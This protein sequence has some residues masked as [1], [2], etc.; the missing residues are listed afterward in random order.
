MEKVNQPATARLDLHQI[1]HEI[2]TQLMVIRCLE[3]GGLSEAA[4]R[5]RGLLAIQKAL[6]EVASGIVTSR[7]TQADLDYPSA[8]PAGDRQ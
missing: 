1:E 7:L 3:K 2:G 4:K 8:S 5:E 6:F